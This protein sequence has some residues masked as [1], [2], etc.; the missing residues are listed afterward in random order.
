MTT[1]P[2][3][4]VLSLGSVADLL[5]VDKAE[6]IKA[7][8]STGPFWAQYKALV[9]SA[10]IVARQFWRAEEQ[11]N[12]LGRYREVGPFVGGLFSAM[13]GS[14]WDAAIGMNEYIHQTA[15]RSQWE[16][17]VVIEK[18]FAAKA[19]RERYDYWA[20]S[21]STHNL[22]PM[23]VAEALADDPNITGISLHLYSLERAMQVEPEVARYRDFIA[24]CPLPVLLGETGR[25]GIG[26][27]IGWQQQGV[28]AADF[29]EEMRW[30]T[31]ATGAWAYTVFC[32]G[33]TEDWR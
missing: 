24:A 17:A 31:Q 6:I 21:M 14:P 7:W 5:L 15:S 18:A 4:F 2:G 16:R 19:R 10:Y 30:L 32:Y 12:V 25:D 3:V 28:S 11:Q 22:P 23:W 8:A 1:F 33:A 27:N 9:P 13:W 20:L 29:A 26:R